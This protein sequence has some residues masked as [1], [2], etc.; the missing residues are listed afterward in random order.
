[1]IVA[2]HV[3]APA[4]AA[5][6]PDAAAASAPADGADFL[7]L[8]QAQ[9]TGATAE[10]LMA[11]PLAAKDKP[12]EDKADHAD[13]STLPA[14]PAAWLAMLTAPVAPVDAKAAPTIESDT[15]D[16]K[17][18]TPVS[19]A[20]L[21]GFKAEE[22]I[23]AD[24]P[25]AGKATRRPGAGSDTDTAA[26]DFSALLH[27]PRAHATHVAERQA[28]Q[29]P[30]AAER[31]SAWSVEPAVTSDRWSDALAL[32]VVMMA[33][34]QVQSAE[35]QLNPPQLGPLEV[36]LTLQNQDATLSFVSPHVAVR[37]AIQS[38]SPQLIEMFAGSGL[39]LTNVNVGTPS[40]QGSQQ[41]NGQSRG[42]GDN[43]EGT[44]A[45]GASAAAQPAYT[46]VLNNW[47]PGGVDT[48][49]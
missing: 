37:E 30:A 32:R 25:A 33:G 2:N 34:Q 20:S 27:A 6:Q 26:V 49:V 42:R 7:S 10:D 11:D 48:F 9:F 22:A 39:N 16:G 4:A 19:T 15:G 41:A 28:T 38:A 12:T 23:L 3:S 18:D 14:D 17:T 29:A 45:V 35:L 24:D 43:Q 8:L 13:A 1:M 31:P 44:E 47:R 5:A 46:R 36:R 21:A 40:Q